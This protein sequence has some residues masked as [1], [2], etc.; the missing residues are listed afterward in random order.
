MLRQITPSPAPR[1]QTYRNNTLELRNTEMTI[2]AENQHLSTLLS[3]T[4]SSALVN[5]YLKI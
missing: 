5:Q 1:H 3:Y 4:R 2:M